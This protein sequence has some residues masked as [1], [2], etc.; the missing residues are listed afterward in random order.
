[1]HSS[2]LILLIFVHIMATRTSDAQEYYTPGVDSCMISGITGLPCNSTL[3]S[4]AGFSF[5]CCG[6]STAGISSVIGGA[7]CVDNTKIRNFT[8]SSVGFLDP[9][10]STAGYVNT[11]LVHCPSVPGAAITSSQ[12]GALQPCSNATVVPGSTSKLNQTLY[13]CG[14]P[15][16]VNSTLSISP[17]V[18]QTSAGTWQCLQPIWGPSWDSSYN[19]TKITGGPFTDPLCTSCLYPSDCGLPPSPPPGP[20][21]PPPPSPPPKPAPPTKSSTD[22]AKVKIN[23]LRCYT[24]V[25][26]TFMMVLI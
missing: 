18:N 12:V 7:A 14:G 8:L 17:F 20:P 15:L 13:C 10:C 6:G 1:M 24:A 19:M 26:M 2:L 9:I 22:T 25:I 3:Q 5:Y 11:P 23:Y 21:S 16:Y 4:I